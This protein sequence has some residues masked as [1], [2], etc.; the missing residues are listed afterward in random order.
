M[1]RFCLILLVCLTCLTGTCFAL[2]VP[3][4]RPS[5]KQWCFDYARV[6]SA[7]V[8]K[9]INDEGRRIQRALDIDFVVMVVPDLAGRTIT[10]YTVDMFSRWKIGASTQGKKGILILIAVKE[11]QVRIEIGYD[12]EGVYT[13]AYVGQVEREILKE[14][15]E[16]AEWHIGFLATLESFVFRLYNRDLQDDVKRLTSSADHL[17]HYSQGAGANNVFDFGAA[18]KKPTPTLPQDIQAYF[19]AQPTPDLAFQRYMELSAKAIKHHGQLTLFTDLSNTFWKG[20]K[21]TSGQSKAEAR[22][23]SGRPYYIKVLD[24]HAVVFFPAQNPDN[25]KKSCM[26]FLFHSPQGWQVDINTMT[27]GMRCVGPGWWIMTDIFHAYS[28]IILEEYNLVNGFLTPWGDDRGY[29]HFYALGSGLY[30]D[31]EPGFHIGVSSRYADTSNLR[32]G[33]SVLKVNGQKIRDWRHFESFFAAAPSG[34]PFTFEL[35]RNGRRMTVEETLPG[36]PD[37]FKLYRPC[38]KTPR[39]WLG[40]YMVQSL[41]KE[42]RHTITL[43]NQGKFR[44]SSLCAILDVFPGSPADK[45]GLKPNDLIVDY[46]RPDDNGEIMPR[47]VIDCLYQTPPGESIHLTVVR[48]LNTILKVTVTPEETWQRGYF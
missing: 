33:D 37:G 5:D 41:D 21:S 47:D 1:R 9:E 22:E 32:R 15:L 27:R 28:Q 42:W 39:R 7:E 19:S 16:Q 3:A 45:A 25:L 35:L 40:V 4:N 36:N 2:A 31:D 44:Y 12:L 13:D 24:Q 48:D 20:W 30:N 11:Q 10:D 23:I 26:Y 43:R 6:L 29:K 38:L 14:F 17:K 8:E 46:G 18:L 34:T